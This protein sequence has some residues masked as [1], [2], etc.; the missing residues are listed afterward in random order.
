MIT[1]YL[2]CLY[3]FHYL[4]IRKLLVLLLWLL[5]FHGISNS[6]Y[7]CYLSIHIMMFIQSTQYGLIIYHAEFQIHLAWFKFKFNV[8]LMVPTHSDSKFGDGL[9]TL[10]Q[11]YWETVMICDWHIHD[12]WNMMKIMM[13][14]DEILFRIFCFQDAHQI[15]RFSRTD[16]ERA[17]HPHRRL[18][19][20]VAVAGKPKISRQLTWSMPFA[21]CR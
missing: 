13:K 4:N 19:A 15:M 2:Y 20:V 8:R 14:Y 16:P 5:E 21:T 9:H 12:I 7:H 3:Y 6:W 10:Y 18:V 11:H 1:D 17:I